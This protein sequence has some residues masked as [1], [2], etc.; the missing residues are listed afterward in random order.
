M[1]IEKDNKQSGACSN[2]PPKGRETRSTCID[3]LKVRLNVSFEAE[4]PKFKKLFDILR[5]YDYEINFQKGRNAYSDMASLA[6][7]I[8]LCYGGKFTVTKEGFQ[9]SL[10]EMSGSGCREFEARYWRNHPDRGY[11]TR[12]SIIREG[13]IKLFEECIV[14]GVVCTRI[15]LPTDDFSG[16]ITIP[17]LKSKIHSKEYSTRMRKLELTDSNEQLIAEEPDKLWDQTTINDAKLT[18]YSATFGNR[19]HVQLCIYDKAAEQHNKGNFLEYKNWIRYEVRYYHENAEKEFYLLLDALKKHK[20][21]EHI[22]GCLSG[23]MEFKEPIADKHHRC[24]TQAW[25]KWK[26]FIGDVPKHAGFSVLPGTPTIKSNALW[27]KKDAALS[28]CKVVTVIDAPYEEIITAYIRVALDKLTPE[29]LQAINQYLT[30]KGK[31]PFESIEQI[32]AY[33]LARRD[34]TSEVSP[35]VIEL[36]YSI[37][38]DNNEKENNDG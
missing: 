33:H 30:S 1:S 16:L 29:H 17:E 11:Y 38:K 19:K 22:V 15:D 9:T 24:T 10:L 23:L 13:W 20:E 26:E 18:G 3:Y 32:K 8:S 21:R 12:E 36:I 25:T 2:T 28:I 34:F 6:P 27:L 31:K 4:R 37:D 7:G 5:I 35:G 14:L